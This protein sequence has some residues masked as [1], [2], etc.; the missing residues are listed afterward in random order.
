MFTGNGMYRVRSVWDACVLF[1]LQVVYIVLV[2]FHFDLSTRILGVDC[3]LISDWKH[4]HLFFSCFKHGFTSS[5][6]QH[7]SSVFLTLLMLI[8]V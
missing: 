6:S 5:C 7:S 2:C 4:D 1:A 8:N 3:P